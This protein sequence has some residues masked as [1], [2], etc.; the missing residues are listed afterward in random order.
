MGHVQDQ[1]LLLQLWANAA[2]YWHGHSVG[3]TN[4]ALLQA[5]GAGAPTLAFDTPFNR[6]VLGDCDQLIADDRQI[7][8]QALRKL[9]GAPDL[10]LSLAARQQAIIANSYGW[11]DVCA[12]YANLL[13][14]IVPRAEGRRETPRDA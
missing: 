6:E 1:D 7:L 5:M 4:P 11:D 9:L 12:R 3:G 8:A 13:Q 10:R 14:S 2:V